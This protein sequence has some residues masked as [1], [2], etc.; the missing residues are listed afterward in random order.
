MGSVEATHQMLEALSQ[1]LAAKP[2]LLNGADA[3]GNTAL[4]YAVAQRRC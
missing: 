2:R 3:Q 1:F 4:H